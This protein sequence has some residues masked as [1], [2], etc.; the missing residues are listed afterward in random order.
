[1]RKVTRETARAFL[2]GKPKTVGNT[3]TDGQSY[4]LHGNKIAWTHGNWRVLTLAGWN[5]V[6][7]RER[8]NG[9]LD[10]MNSE[11]RLSQK[12]FSPILRNIKNGIEVEI[13][14]GERL[15]F[16]QDGMLGRFFPDVGGEE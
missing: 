7:T 8:L 5:T 6:T 14:S 10:L 4:E 16:T 11:W 3:E 9:I 13:D 12:D 15:V 2:A 1:M